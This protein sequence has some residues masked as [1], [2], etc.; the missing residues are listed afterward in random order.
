MFNKLGIIEDVGGPMT[1]ERNVY[2]ANNF[3]RYYTGLSTDTLEKLYEFY[4]VDFELFGYDVPARLWEM[5]KKV[6]E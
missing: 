2:G 3:F 5:A 1:G 4:K 6:E